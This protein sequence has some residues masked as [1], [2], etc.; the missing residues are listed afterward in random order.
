MNYQHEV[1]GLLGIYNTPYYKN[2]YVAE[3]DGLIAAV[4]TFFN[5]TGS[6]YQFT[7][8]V[9]GV[10]VYSQKG[11][12]EFRGYSTIKL[13]NY[14][15]IKKGDTF[16]VVFKN[17]IPYMASSRLH[18]QANVS[19]VS[20]DGKEWQDLNEQ[21]SIALLKVYTVKDLGIASNLVKY[22]TDKTPLVATV[23]AGEAVVFELNSEKSKVVADENDSAK[24]PI[25]LKPGSYKVTVTYK[26]TTIITSVL[27]KS[28]VIASNVKKSF[29]KQL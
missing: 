9:N 21:D 7:I 25:N 27:V 11:V 24:L 28:T 10:S 26:N 15:Q 8:H 19:F 13:D 20:E 3:K 29:R 18:D 6:D 1:S 4:G 17:K 14:I 23:G 22:Y 2:T 16:D 12:S 5:K